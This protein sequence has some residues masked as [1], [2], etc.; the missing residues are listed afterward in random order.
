MVGNI[1]IVG[2]PQVISGQVVTAT[3][4]VCYGAIRD[5]DCNN[6]NISLNELH[7]DLMLC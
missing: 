7:L 2:G 5:L 1:Y 4:G 3:T 6:K